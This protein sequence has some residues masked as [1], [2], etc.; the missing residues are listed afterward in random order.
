M[1]LN[2]TQSWYYFTYNMQQFHFWRKR[3]IFLHIFPKCHSELA[4]E[5]IEYS[6]GFANNFYRRLPLKEKRKKECFRESVRSALSRERLTKHNVRK[7][8]QR[9]RGYTC[10]HFAFAFGNNSQL[11]QGKNISPDMIEKMV[12]F[13]KTHRCALDF[14]GKYI[15]KIKQA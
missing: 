7:F 3:L 13:F 6:W 11:T 2:S 4:G 12:K 1:K 14:E 8:A 15:V 9:A 5:G 10:A